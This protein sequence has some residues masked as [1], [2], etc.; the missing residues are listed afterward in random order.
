MDTSWIVDSSTYICSTATIVRLYD[1]T[2]HYSLL[3][4]IYVVLYRDKIK[5][6]VRD[7]SRIMNYALVVAIHT[8]TN[9]MVLSSTLQFKYGKY[10]SYLTISI[11]KNYEI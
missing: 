9:S 6:E 11:Y 2:I 1:C 5:A 4:P 7:K 3:L 10:D 8:H